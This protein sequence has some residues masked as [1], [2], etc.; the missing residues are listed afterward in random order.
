MRT[1]VNVDDK[2]LELAKARAHERHLTLGELV[3]AALR[4]H[5]TRE[6]SN[7]VVPLPVFT[8]GTGMRSDID[9]R[10]NRSLYEA[11]EEG[12]DAEMTRQFPRSTTRR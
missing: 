2:L 12:A 6:V 9:P 7:R 3:E 10:S 8:P 1:T 11:L 4:E 5:L